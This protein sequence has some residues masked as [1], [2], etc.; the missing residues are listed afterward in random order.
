MKRGTPYH[1][2]TFQLAEALKIPWAMAIGHLELLFHFTAQYAPQGNI[3]KFSAK[4]IASGIGWNGKPEKI[5]DALV[6]TGWLDRSEVHDYL[7]HGWSEHVDRSTLQRLNRLGLSTIQQNQGDTAKVC[8]QNVSLTCTPPVPEPEPEPTTTAHTTLAGESEKPTR[9]KPT[10]VDAERVRWF[11]E[12]Y[13]LYPRHEAKAAATKVFMRVIQ[14]Q[15]VF[16][17]MMSSLK[18]QLPSLLAKEAQYRPLP[19]TW[20]NQRRWEDELPGLTLFPK[21]TPPAAAMMR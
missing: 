1:P 10:R 8:T 3:G 11:E 18:L 2:K 21:S 4:R 9:V 15:E 14:K 19:A 20:L 13:L 12:F 5:L 17:T 7:V 6:L 16:D